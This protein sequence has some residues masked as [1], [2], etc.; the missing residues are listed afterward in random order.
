MTSVMSSI[1]VR[2]TP[3]PRQCSRKNLPIRRTSKDQKPTKAPT[4]K[5]HLSD[6][7]K[8]AAN[9]IHVAEKTVADVK[10]SNRTGEQLQQPY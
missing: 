9:T 10:T 8:G 4:Q 3:T 2:R 5:G 1:V 6:H 7:G